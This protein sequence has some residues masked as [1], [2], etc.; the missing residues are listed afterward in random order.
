MRAECGPLKC[1]H[2][3]ADIPEVSRFCLSC[4]KII[5]SP[6]GVVTG[7]TDDTDDSFLPM[8]LFGLAFMML[9]FALAPMFM[10]LWI[11]ALLMVVAG[12]A[13]VGAG[14]YLTRTNKKHEERYHQQINAKLK[15][16]YCG[17]LNEQTDLKCVSCGAT[18]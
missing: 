18:L 1:P 14:V 15:C 13:M 3:S 5:Q 9:F 16:R 8:M 4:G 11:G 17:T 7:Q 12:L 10:G 2:C 6:T